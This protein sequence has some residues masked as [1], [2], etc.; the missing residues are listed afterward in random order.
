ML[1]QGIP[2][3]VELLLHWLPHCCYTVFTLWL[4]CC[5][6]VATLLVYSCHTVVILHLLKKLATSAI[7]SH[8]RTHRQMDAHRTFIRIHSQ[9]HIHAGATYKS[10]TYSHRQ[11]NTHTHSHT[12]HTLTHTHTQRFLPGDE[13]LYALRYLCCSV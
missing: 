5:R 9:T 12:T 4:H 11:R 1:V 3:V 8:T 2:T 7:W 6:S 10:H 13:V